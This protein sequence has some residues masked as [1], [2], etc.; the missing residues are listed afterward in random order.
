[1]KAKTVIVTSKFPASLEI[2]WEKL[3]K[4]E[5][6]QQI[7]KPYATFNP[8][9]STDL[10]WQEGNISQ[11]KLKLFGFIPMGIHT[12]K[13]IQINKKDQII[14]TN[15]SNKSVPVWN[16]QITLSKIDES[17]TQYTDL[18]EINAGWKTSFVYIW[19][20]FFINTGNANGSTY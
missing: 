20:K 11:L 4:L 9:C 19:S 13:V 2:I 6:L 14:Y 5:T 16:H 10:I 7:A 18:V 12:I 17:T 15:E 1:M 8:I 3:Q